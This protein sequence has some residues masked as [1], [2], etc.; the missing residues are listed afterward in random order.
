M[1]RFYAHRNTNRPFGLFVIVALEP[2]RC[3]A[4]MDLPAAADYAPCCCRLPMPRT[5]KPKTPKRPVSDVRRSQEARRDATRARILDATLHC[6]ATYGYAGTG[7][8]QVVAQARVSRGAWAHHFP[9]MTVLIQEAAQHLMA[10]VYERLGAVLQ[11]LA[12][13]E[14]D[15]HNMILAVWREFFASEVNEVYLE[16]LIASRREPGL[17]EK[18]TQLSATLE[19]NL[20]TVT[21]RRFESLQNAALEPIELLLLSRW[22]LRGI[23]LDAPLMPD[24]KLDLAL[25]AWSRL[26]GTQM[27][28]RTLSKL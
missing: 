24:G 7:V 22:V 11:E 21:S 3:Q 14:G 26:L 19:R 20:D 13:T 23:A 28:S 12:R 25:S 16:L 4:D 9:S 6:L 27:R 18:L 8:A 15:A 17:A 10:R 1:P 5:P 2:K